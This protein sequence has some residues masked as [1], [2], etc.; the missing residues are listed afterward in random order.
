MPTPELELIYNGE[1]YS[2][3]M[4]RKV[5]KAFGKAEPQYRARCLKLRKSTLP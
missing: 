2:V 1:S 4:T 5:A 3:W